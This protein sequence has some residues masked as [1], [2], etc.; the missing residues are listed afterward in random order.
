MSDADPGDE[1]T[2]A[3]ADGAERAEREPEPDG[4]RGRPLTPAARVLAGAALAVALIGTVVG[5]VALTTSDRA[6]PDDRVASK[7][8]AVRGAGPLDAG[9]AMVQ[10]QTVP[11]GGTGTFE[12][13]LDN[14]GTTPIVVRRVQVELLDPHLRVVSIRGLAPHRPGRL[15]PIEGYVLPPQGTVPDDQTGGIQLRLSLVR[16]G[17]AAAVGLRVTYVGG[18]GTTERIDVVWDSWALCTPTVDGAPCAPV[19]LNALLRR[20]GTPVP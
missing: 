6:T 15:Q 1:P 8:P 19:S 2:E 18:R 10:G 14:V 16:P 12:L 20:A 9:M 17:D 11:L 7:V 13:A 3:G 5:L 4:P